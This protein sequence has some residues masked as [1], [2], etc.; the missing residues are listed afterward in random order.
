MVGDEEQDGGGIGRAEVGVDGGEFFFLLAAAVEC[1]EVADEE[2]LE[3][4][5][6]RGRLGAVEDFEDGGFGEVEVVEGEVARVGR[7]ERGEDGLAAA[8]VEEDL[9]AE[10]DV[11]GAECCG[12]AISVRKRSVAK[13]EARLSGERPS[14]RLQHIAYDGLGE[15]A[16]EALDGG[17][18]SWMKPERSWVD[19]YCL[20]KG[21][22]S[23]W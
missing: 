23:F 21:R 6:E 4:R 16:G 11:A 5:H 19:W 15:I 14:E 13:R 18:S 2:D 1:L 9:V 20:R 3:G 10:E 17:G 7:G 8:L 22:A 12:E